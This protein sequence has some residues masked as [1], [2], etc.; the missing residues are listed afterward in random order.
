MN[1]FNQSI[2]IAFSGGIK[3]GKTAISQNIASKLKWNRVSFG[4]YIRNI[5]KEKDLTPSREILQQIGEEVIKQGLKK[6]CKNVLDMAQWENGE[7]LIIDGIRHKEIFEI[8]KKITNPS[9]IYLIY[10]SLDVKEREKRIDETLEINKLKNYD[11]H[12]T[13]IQVISTLSNIS[14]LIV[15]GN[16]QID[17]IVSEI[18]DWITNK[19]N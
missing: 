11:Q 15:D 7:N 1:S 9:N 4:D 13:E 12:S 2:I 5:A 6:F 10:I 14:D 19:E 3:S 17:I 18:L 8:I 16:K